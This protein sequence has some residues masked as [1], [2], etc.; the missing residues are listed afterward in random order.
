MLGIRT[1]HRLSLALHIGAVVAADVG[2]FVP[3]HT[4][5]LEGIVD[6]IHRALDK[7]ALVGVLDAQ[8]E[9]ATVLL[10]I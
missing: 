6:N 7:A 3:I 5:V 2:A 10:G 8:D 9:L 1:I 4:D